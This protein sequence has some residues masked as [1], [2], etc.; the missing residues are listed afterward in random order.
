MDDP[1]ATDGG[2]GGMPRWVKAFVVVGLVLGLAV[3]VATFAGG[4]HGPGRH[5]GHG[6]GVA[7]PAAAR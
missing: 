1:T 2:T 3:L 7:P 5:Q 4:E 6:P